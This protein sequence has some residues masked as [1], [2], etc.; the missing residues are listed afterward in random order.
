MQILF[1]FPRVENQAFRP[2]YDRISWRNDETEFLLWCEGRTGYPMVDAGMRELNAT[3]FMHN[4]V[5][6]IVASF[7]VKHLNIP[8]EMHTNDDL[9][10]ATANAIAGLRAG[11]M[12]VNTTVN[13]LGERAGNAALEEV[14]MALKHLY[15]IDTGIITHHLPELS[16]LVQKATGKPIPPWKAIVGQNVYTH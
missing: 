11:A 14:V 7:L 8:I 12:S 6:M 5:R 3:G 2:E 13:G 10:M 9:G 1:H 16:H 4:R 15:Q